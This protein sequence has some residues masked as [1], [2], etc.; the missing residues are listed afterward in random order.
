MRNFFNY[1]FNKIRE[2]NQKYAT[3]RAKM[4]KGAG[5]ALFILRIYLILLMGILVFKFIIV[6]KG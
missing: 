3:P 2:I 1:H 6:V 4:T 5:L